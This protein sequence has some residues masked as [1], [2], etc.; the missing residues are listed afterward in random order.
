MLAGLPLG[1]GGGGLWHGSNG[2]ITCM[3]GM[4]NLCHG[5][6]GTIT[7]TIHESQVIT[8]WRDDILS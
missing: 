3:D 6:Q 7:Q 8:S 4:G 2:W 1:V 5:Y